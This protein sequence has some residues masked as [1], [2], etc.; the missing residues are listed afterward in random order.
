MTVSLENYSRLWKWKFRK[1]RVLIQ[2]FLRRRVLEVHHV[3]STAVPG[4][5]AK[6]IIDM[7][8]VVPDFVRA[9]T[10]VEKMN[11]LGYEYKGANLESRQYF[12][13][14]R[15]NDRRLFVRSRERC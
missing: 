9:Y 14:Q 12:F 3:G 8:A 7:I 10:C 11:H 2:L 1:E 4:M 5:I 15:R 6:P 13:H